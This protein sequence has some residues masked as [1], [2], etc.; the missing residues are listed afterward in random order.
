METKDLSIGVID[1]IELLE[2]YLDPLGNEHFRK[3]K[4]KSSKYE[5]SSSALL[6]EQE[7]TKESLVK[8][9]FMLL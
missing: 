7:A 4:K 6:L 5:V 2:I 8:L 3:K 9:L 1:L